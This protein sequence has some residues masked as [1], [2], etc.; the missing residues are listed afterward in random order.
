MVLVNKLI[1]VI[2]KGYENFIVIFRSFWLLEIEIFMYIV[3]NMK[4]FYYDW[5]LYVI[6]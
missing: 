3:I 1:K 2:W 4:L 6:I 5:N